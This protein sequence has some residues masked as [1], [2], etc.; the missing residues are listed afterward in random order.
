MHALHVVRWLVCTIERLHN[1]SPQ[2]ENVLAE[3]VEGYTVPE[4]KLIHFE[5]S[6]EVNTD[7]DIIIKRLDDHIEYEGTEWIMFADSAVNLLSAVN[8]AA[9]EILLGESVSTATD[10]WSLGV[11][12]YT[13]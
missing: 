13:L 10:M 12:L 7:S 1:I 8:I 6:R 3:E 11:L 4:I 5:R 9:P 2:P